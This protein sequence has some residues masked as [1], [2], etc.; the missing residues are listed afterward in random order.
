MLFRSMKMD[1]GIDTGDMILKEEIEIAS[2]ETGGTLHERLALTGLSALLKGMKQIESNTAVYEKQGESPTP[3]VG[4]LTKEMGNLDFKQPAIVL[5]R[6]VRGLNPWPSAYTKLDQKTLKIWRAKVQPDSMV[7]HSEYE[8][9][10]ICSISKESFCIA[11]KDGG[12]EVQEL[13]LE[14]KKRMTSMDF[15]RGYSLMLGTKLGD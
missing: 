3:Y 10:Q 6:L 7:N 13:Q 8:C 11:T 2:D 9:G 1:T 14:G 4:R 5:E 15:L 12:L